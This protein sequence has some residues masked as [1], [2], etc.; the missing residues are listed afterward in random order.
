MPLGSTR[1]FVLGSSAFSE[2]DRLIHLL[3]VER[4]ILR[5]IAP[6]SMKVRNRFGSLFELF[7]EGEFHYYWQENRELITVSKGDIINSYFKTVSDPQNIFYFY[8]IADVLLHFVPVNHKEKR[9]YRLLHSILTQGKEGI[10][11]D[12]LL[13]Y[14]LVWTL[15]IEGM[16]FNPRLCYNCY[17]KNLQQAWFKTDFRGILCHKCKTTEHLGLDAEE[18]NY[19]Q[20]TEKHSPKEVETWKG[21]IDT[22]KL[23][24]AF[25][26][27]IQ[28]HGECTLKSAQYLTEFR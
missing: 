5:A 11:I 17:D 7:T 3:T 2:Q 16:M 19:I 12:L 4:G 25:T 9:L 22:P 13:L 18:L 20:W 21:R 27:K 23:I 8:L 24:R 14:F 15:R 10:Q 1:A 26:K 6:G 28:H